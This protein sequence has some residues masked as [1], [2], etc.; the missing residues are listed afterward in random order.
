M[1]GQWAKEVKGDMRKC[2]LLNENEK[3]TCQCFGMQLAFYDAQ[4]KQL[5]RSI[6]AMT[7]ASTLRNED[8]K[9]KLNSK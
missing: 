3:T 5:R 4:Q 8:K 6:K 2:F 1:N 9:H 7:S